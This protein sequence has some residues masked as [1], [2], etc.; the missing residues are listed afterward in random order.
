MV[1][2]L[3]FLQIGSHRPLLR[4]SPV[5]LGLHPL[6]DSRPGFSIR[7]LGLAPK[8]NFPDSKVAL[9]KVQ[10]EDI[11]SLFIAL[12]EFWKVESRKDYC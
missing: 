9:S 8:Y 3:N 1:F 7:R 6:F 2:N 11:S 5:S 10:L 12:G 4:P